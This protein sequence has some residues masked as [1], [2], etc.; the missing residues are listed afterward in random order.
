MAGL[1]GEEIKRVEIKS[2]AQ[3]DALVEVESD[4]EEA[5]GYCTEFIF[6]LDPGKMKAFKEERLR[7]ELERLPGNSIVVV[8][9]DDIVKVHVHTLKPGNALNTAQRY[10]E[11]IKL[12]IENM[13][14]QHNSILEASAGTPVAE[15][16]ATPV[17]PQ[18]EKEVA[19]ISVA[20]GDGIKD[21]FLELHCDHVV[22]G[23][24]TM[25]PSAEDIVAA[26][27]NVNAKHV[28]ILPNNSNIVMTAQQ[29]SIILEDEVDVQVVP[30]KT[31]PQGLSACIMYN[32]EVSLEENL[33]EMK[34]AIA[35]VKT[36]QVTFAIKDTNIDGVDI[37]ANQYMALC[38]KEIT[39]C[40]PNKIDALKETLNGLVDDDSEIITLIYGEDVTEDEVAEVEAFIE[41]NYEAELE[42]VNGA[43]PVYSFIVGVE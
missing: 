35:N 40:V 42:C 12:K 10:G 8:Q 34:D 4:S 27:R 24:Q 11:F 6:R 31:I 9:D 28:I 13:Q 39:A 32:P 36:G 7:N 17:V 43:Q 38:E 16:T 33:E 41:D 5:Y 3:K 20:A 22:S 1:A 23:G 30:S 37:K 14:E 25:N 29:A 19:I 15:A 21:M 18:P 2:E 26:I